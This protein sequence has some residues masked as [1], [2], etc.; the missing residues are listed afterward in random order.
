MGLESLQRLTLE[1]SA[2]NFDKA[3][4]EVE[5]LDAATKK[6]T[7]GTT[8]ATEATK[9]Q[10]EAQRELNA[11][12]EDFVSLLSRIHPALGGFVD[13][14]IKASKIAGDLASQN[15]DWGKSLETTKNLVTENAS[16][17]KLLGA[18]GAALAG[19]QAIAFAWGQVK[20]EE[21]A[22]LAALRAYVTEQ[23]RIK[24]ETLDRQT[25]IEGLSDTRREG[26]FSAAQ[27]AAAVERANR[28]GERFE[29][30]DPSAIN[31]AAAFLPDASDAD[32]VDASFLIQSGKL[33]L[34]GTLPA[35]RRSALFAGARRRNAG[36]ISGFRD[37]ESAQLIDRV[38]AAQRESSGQGTGTVNIEDFIRSLPGDVA[39]GYD[40]ERLAEIVAA[41]PQLRGG[42][43]GLIGVQR[44]VDEV[45][46]AGEQNRAYADQIFEAGY[47]SEELGLPGVTTAE[48]NTARFVRQQL[49]KPR[50]DPTIVTNYYNSRHFGP[51]DTSIRDRSM[52]AFKEAKN[53]EKRFGGP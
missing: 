32:I 13:A 46:T 30:L 3:Q 28:I 11:T 37:R 42:K 23:S 43:A 8:E 14:G 52:N 18:G 12:N 5:N 36:A 49:D 44:A 6:A 40:P 26:G 10:T 4:R 45:V 7:G 35:G 25:A 31:Q 29:Q 34:D 27:S 33:A 17:L 50:S 53:I 1:A 20:K 9:Q 16:A 39:K 38:Q 41:L 22:A 24:R 19:V 48:V 2:K 47:I 15:I 21:E 51:D